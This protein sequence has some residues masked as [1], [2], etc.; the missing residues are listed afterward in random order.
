[1]TRNIKSQELL[2]I[3]EFIAQL[4]TR[5]IFFRGY[6]LPVFSRRF[7]LLHEV[8]EMS[9]TH[10]FVFLECSD[11][12]QGLI[13]CVQQVFTIGTG[14]VKSPRFYQAL[15]NAT[16]D[17]TGVETRC[18]IRKIFKRAFPFTLFDNL[19]RCG[20]ADSFD[21]GQTKAYG[22]FALI[23]QNRGKVL[24]RLIDIWTVD[25]DIHR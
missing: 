17:I 16:I 7:L 3:L 20:I 6:R 9:L 19:Y 14:G 1:M 15:V 10:R 4:H 22:A 13:E 5:L 25:R 24:T 2:F 8:K 12:A 21:R 11:S 23:L 18:K